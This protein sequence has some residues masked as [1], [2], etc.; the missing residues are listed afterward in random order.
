MRITKSLESLKNP[1]VTIAEAAVA[2]GFEDQSY[3]TRAFKKV[4]GITPTEWRRAHLGK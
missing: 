1:D 4:K 3:Y 2:S